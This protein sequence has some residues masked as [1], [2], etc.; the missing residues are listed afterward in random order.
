MSGT[1]RIHGWHIGFE[2]QKL[3]PPTKGF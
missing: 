3:Y 1:V 2:T